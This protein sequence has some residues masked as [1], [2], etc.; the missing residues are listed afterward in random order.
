MLTKVELDIVERFARMATLTL[1]VPLDWDKNRKLLL[2]TNSSIKFAL[3][4]CNFVISIFYVIFQFVRLLPGMGYI[5]ESEKNKDNF[6][7]HF[8]F[9]IIELFLAIVQWHAFTHTN[10]WC[11]WFNQIRQFNKTAGEQIL[12]KFKFRFKIFNK[13]Q[14]HYIWGRNSWN[15]AFERSCWLLSS[16]ASWSSSFPLFSRSRVIIRI[17][18]ILRCQKSFKHGP[19]LFSSAFLKPTTLLELAFFTLSLPSLSLHT[20]SRKTFGWARPG[21]YSFVMFL[22]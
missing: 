8:Y 10:G 20:F 12:N 7:F 21:E 22:L 9:I 16:G 5:Y 4:V 17:L 11:S 13:F 14:V 15:Q 2:P 3:V 18:F 1:S 19:H 6:V